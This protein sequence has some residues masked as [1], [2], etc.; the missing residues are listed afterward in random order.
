M[1]AAHDKRVTAWTQTGWCQTDLE[2]NNGYACHANTSC[3]LARAAICGAQ[4]HDTMAVLTARYTNGVHAGR[5]S[6]E[7]PGINT[8]QLVS[9]VR[10]DQLYKP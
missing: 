6:A 1:Y 9:L 10:D 7:V 2:R 4:L 5:Q 3:P 8:L